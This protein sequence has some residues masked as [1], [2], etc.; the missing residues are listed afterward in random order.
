MKERNC[1]AISYSFRRAR[2]ITVQFPW[3]LNDALQGPFY[4][5]I[6]VKNPD[7]VAEVNNT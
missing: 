2:E 1:Q 4:E 6:D 5:L 3:N 7:E